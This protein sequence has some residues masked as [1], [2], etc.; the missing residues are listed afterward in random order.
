MRLVRLAALVVAAVTGLLVRVRAV[1]ATRQAQPHLKA[2]M[3]ALVLVLMAAQAVVVALVPLGK[4]AAL[5]VAMVVRVQHL[6]SQGLPSPMLAVV[7]A[8][9][10]PIFMA[11]QADRVA[12]AAAAM[13]AQIQ[14]VTVL[15]ALQIGAAVVAAAPAL[16]TA[17]VAVTAALA[18]LSFAHCKPLHQP[19]ARQL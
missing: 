1:L 10:L 11:E 16:M 6:P 7:A 14:T 15:M 12:Q 5:M 3:A 18:W 19:Q 2:L 13:G 4:M 8:V 17:L 9:R